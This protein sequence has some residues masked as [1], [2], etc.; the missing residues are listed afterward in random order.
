[1]D[2]GLDGGARRMEFFEGGR[3][4]HGACG[5]AAGTATPRRAGTAFA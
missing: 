5:N 2:L 4:L 1:V 3:G